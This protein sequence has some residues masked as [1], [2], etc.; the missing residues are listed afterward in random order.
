M[1]W[2]FAGIFAGVIA[3]LLLVLAA[4]EL[5]APPLCLII[6]LGAAQFALACWWSI[7]RARAAL[8]PYNWVIRIVPQ[9]LLL[10]FRGLT[11]RELP[12]GA[13]SILLLDRSDIRSVAKRVEKRFLAASDADHQGWVTHSFIE[14]RLAHG[15]A[16]GLAYHMS[17]EQLASP[18]DVPMSLAGRDV[19]RI[20]FTERNLRP[21]IDEAVKGLG[22]HF[23]VAPPVFCELK[24]W[25]MLN[26]REAVA[27]A[28][29]MCDR[30]EFLEAVEVLSERGGFK[31]LAAA[32]Y[33]DERRARRA[34]R[35]PNCGY[36][37]RASNIRCPECGTPISRSA[38]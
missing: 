1:K 38:V 22:R 6:V 21:R 15:I 27:Y 28:D 35:C 7:R 32:Q 12:D 24:D 5:R 25:R 29:L 13:P 17:T 20:S 8:G 16:G 9:G 31:R 30:G 4:S 2:V 19:I 3:L 34:I 26:T 33:V 10:N 11:R 36:D 23:A 18:F 37:L 14:V